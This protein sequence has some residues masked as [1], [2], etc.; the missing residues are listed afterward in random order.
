MDAITFELIFKGIVSL[1]VA[2]MI[3]ILKEL[4]TDFRKLTDGLSAVAINLQTL[5]T[6]DTHKD[7]AISEIKK[8]IAHN[9][10]EINLLKLK[11]ALLEKEE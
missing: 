1:G 7:E 6:K 4:K 5:L 8:Q 11:I 10:K 2:L 9:Q 3:F